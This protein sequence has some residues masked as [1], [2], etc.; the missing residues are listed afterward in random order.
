MSKGRLMKAKYVEEGDYLPGL[1]NGYVFEV[2]ENNGYLSYPRS[3]YG[4]SAAMPEDTVLI[5][6]HDAQG[7]ECY[8]LLPGN[9]RLTVEGPE[10]DEED[11]DD[12][13]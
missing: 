1:D 4:M 12:D 11:E 2:E 9:T 10:R 7:D 3:G 8:L 5:G 13:Y 6:Y